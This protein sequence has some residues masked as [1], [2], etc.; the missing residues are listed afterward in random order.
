MV[1]VKARFPFIVS[2]MNTNGSSNGSGNGHDP[3]PKKRDKTIVKFPS[4]AERD[5]M[6]REER[7]EEERWRKQYR[8]QSRA[9][10][11]P[12]FK[13]GNIPPVTKALVIALIL[14][15]LPLYVL[16]D[17]AQR[18]SVFYQFGFIPGMYTG[19]FEWS[20]TGLLSPLTH[21]FIHGSWPHLLLNAIMGL[22]LGL[23]F[24]NKFGARILIKFFVI[25]TFSGI[26][27]YTALDPFTTTPVIGASSGISGLFG[28]LIFVMIVQNQSHPITQRFGQYG[29]WPMLIFWGVIIVAPGMLMGDNIAW[30]AHLGGYIAGVALLIGL[31]KGKIRL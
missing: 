19:T 8:A 6:K 22:V 28:A 12:F 16:M 18:L 30:K 25:C 17:E 29:P 2:P 20:W 23:F 21:A 7:E 13:A 5:R 4:L 15:H 10:R 27:L 31:Q 26:A 14:A 9:N 24:E 1:V 11:E 3:G